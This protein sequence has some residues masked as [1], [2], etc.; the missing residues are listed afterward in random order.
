MLPK[1][2]QQLA[3]PLDSAAS[4]IMFRL[5]ELRFQNRR[6]STPIGSEEI[7][8]ISKRGTSLKLLSRSDKKLMKILRYEYLGISSF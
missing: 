6:S 8:F 7:G 1:D 3:G 4:S 2:T 5:R